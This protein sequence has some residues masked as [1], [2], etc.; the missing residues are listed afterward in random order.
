M[1]SYEQNDGI[2][3]TDIIKLFWKKILW[4]LMALVI[5]VAAG[6]T[7]GFLKNTRNK[8]YGTQLS[9]FVNPKVDGQVNQQIY[10][11]YGTTPVAEMIGQLSKD[12]FFEYLFLD[13]NDLPQKGISAE[14]DAKI[15][16]AEP[17]VKAAKALTEQKE[18][19]L[20]ELEELIEDF[21][22]STTV[23]KV[24]VDEDGL[25]TQ[26]IEDA[27]NKREGDDKITQQE[28]DA[29]EKALEK[30]KPLDELAAVAKE[31]VKNEKEAVVKADE[32]AKEAIA[33]WQK[34]ADYAKYIPAAKQ[35]I[36]YT[37]EV[38]DEDKTVATS[39]IYV[40]IQLKNNE[41]FA[42]I[43]REKL[44]ERLPKYVEENMYV[45]NG[46][47]GTNCSRMSRT[48]DIVCVTDQK[49]FST[50]V[51]NGILFGFAT[52]AVACVVILILNIGTLTKK[53]EETQTP[54]NE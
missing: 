12:H 28:K 54:D 24:Y 39:F 19:K 11:V 52:T 34:T 32:A 8:V 35:A 46:F 25:P 48:D 50:I 21:N 13:E 30:A 42:K 45:P 44:V 53:Q 16:V 22:Y 15:A 43:L 5:G 51:K 26:K 23:I 20:K 29:I 9:F 10:G 49:M 18:A 36:K 17:I 31:L 2:R 37:R 4:I 27:I 1:S 3:L 6:A 14:V 7:F 33:Q 38:S 41:E 40:D 47:D